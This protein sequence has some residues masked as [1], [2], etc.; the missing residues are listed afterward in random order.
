MSARKLSGSVKRIIGLFSGLVVV[1]GAVFGIAVFNSISNTEASISVGVDSTVYDVNGNKIILENPAS[2]YKSNLGDYRLVDSKSKTYSLGENTVIYDSGSLKIL[3][4]G[5]QVVSDTDVTL[6]PNFSQIDELN[7]A[8][9]FKLADRVYL[10]TGNSIGGEG[11]PV[12][13][14]GYLFIVM[15]KSGN[16]MLLNDEVCEKTT[17]ASAINVDGEYTFDIANE[18]LMYGEDKVV[19]CSLIIGSTN[20]YDENSDPMAIRNKIE[21]LKEQG[22]DVTN[23]DEVLIDAKG[24]TGGRGGNGG[25]GGDGGQGGTGGAG[26]P[27]GEGGTGVAPDVTNARKTLNL[28]QVTPSYTQVD[29]EYYVSDPYGFLGDITIKVTNMNDTSD[30]R[31][32]TCD[33]D[34]SK[35]TIF[36]LVPSTKYMLELEASN[37]A[38]KRSYQYF[39]TLDPEVELSV[40]KVSEDSITCNVKYVQ[41]L[42]LNGARLV[43]S[44]IEK[45]PGS[46]I[47]N[48]PS[49]TIDEAT[50]QTNAIAVADIGYVEASKSTGFTFTFTNAGANN[51]GGAIELGKKG[52]YLAIWIAGATYS[53]KK[54]NI[55]SRSYFTNIVAGK[56]LWESWSE[57]YEECTKY[58]LTLDANG[59][60]PSCMPTEANLKKV[61]NAISDYN[62]NVRDKSARLTGFADWD[63]TDVIGTLNT[64]KKHYHDKGYAGW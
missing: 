36:N 56:G 54:V 15:D 23:P 13:T 48:D 43:L 4:G 9:F 39:Y 18:L 51:G 17:S 24:G 64:I 32:I 38:S 20:E 21:S 11:Y 7:Y 53:G 10:L 19:D 8:G 37:D 29:V 25:M 45:L 35:M 47:D 49:K 62:N 16:A 58:T 57:T 55:P 40:V 30:V 1:L 3:G 34:A 44:E 27:G 31:T 52:K 59:D 26:G 42:T 46:V 12:S 60:Y 63:T 50:A 14:D 6:L 2:V 41:G 61:N 33:L 22:K 28:Y 5:Y